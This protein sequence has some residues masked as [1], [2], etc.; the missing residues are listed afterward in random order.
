M[1]KRL[2]CEAGSMTRASDLAHTARPHVL[3]DPRPPRRRPLMIPRL[4]TD[5]PTRVRCSLCGQ[6]GGPGDMIQRHSLLE[7]RKG[8]VS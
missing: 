4:P 5:I 8:C 7:C 6:W 2:R 1:L 3:A